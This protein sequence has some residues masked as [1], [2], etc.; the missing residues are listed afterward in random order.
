M[1]Q[2]GR[3]ARPPSGIIEFRDYVLH[4]SEFKRFIA[5]SAE[6]ADARTQIYDG[7]L[8][9][10]TADTG[11]N[12]SRVLHLYHFKE[13]TIFRQ[14]PPEL[15]AAIGASCAST[16]KPR[17]AVE[18]AALQAVYE[19]RKYQLRPGR[20]GVQEML[21]AFKTGLPAKLATDRTGQP[22]FVGYSDVGLLNQV[23]E[24]YR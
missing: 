17:T 9:M 7:F 20:S 16:Y 4:A 8:G 21:G 5:L 15:Y 2:E 3:N 11:G 18:E 10:F 22:A 13:S 19:L 6:Y 24:I 23:V 14:A 12:V 1:T